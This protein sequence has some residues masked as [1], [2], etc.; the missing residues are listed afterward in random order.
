MGRLS[1]SGGSINEAESTT[2]AVPASPAIPSA[3]PA[4]DSSEIESAS[5]G[6]GKTNWPR[7]VSIASADRALGRGAQ[8]GRGEWRRPV[9]LE[10]RGAS[11]EVETRTGRA[12]GVTDCGDG[13][14]P[15]NWVNFLDFL[16]R[17]ARSWGWR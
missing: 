15:N 2:S 5:T 11:V 6:L 13:V 3:V 10:E 7:I 16:T 8:M 4:N 12:R 1:S 17:S 14:S 9:L